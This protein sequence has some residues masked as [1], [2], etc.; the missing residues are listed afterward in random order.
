MHDGLSACDFTGDGGRFSLSPG[1]G[2]RVRASVASNLSGIFSH[3]RDSCSLRV[4]FSA[5]DWKFQCDAATI[6][7]LVEPVRAELKRS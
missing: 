2:D 4:M 3:L 6:R 1:E 5:A 7:P